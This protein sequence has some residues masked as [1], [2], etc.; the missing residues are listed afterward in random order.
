MIG[1]QPDDAGPCYAGIEHGFRCIDRQARAYRNRHVRACDREPPTISVCKAGE[2]HAIV[3]GKLAWTLRAPPTRKVGR[4][5]ADHEPDGPDRP[6]DHA[7]VRQR[8]DPDPEIDVLFL[9]I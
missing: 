7:A 2:G 6:R 4:A 1:K 5:G 3:P 9:E 8:A